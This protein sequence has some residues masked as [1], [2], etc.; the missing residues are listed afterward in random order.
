VLQLTAN[1]QRVLQTLSEDHERELYELVPTLI[2]ALTKIRRNCETIG[3]D[4]AEPKR[5]RR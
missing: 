5:K 4:A 1:G 2:Q 3:R